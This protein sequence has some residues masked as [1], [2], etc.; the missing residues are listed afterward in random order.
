M[1][2][3]EEKPAEIARFIMS[4]DEVVFIGKEFFIEKNSKKLLVVKGGRGSGNFG[5]G[6]RAGRQG[7]SGSGG[8]GGKVRESEPDI[9]GTGRIGVKADSG[10]D[11]EVTPLSDQGNDTVFEKDISSEKFIEKSSKKLWIVK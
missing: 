7:G 1:K 3:A 10:V 2:R 6:G 4:S 9:G 5:H 8:G 11:V